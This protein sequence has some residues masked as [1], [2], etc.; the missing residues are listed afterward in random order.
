MGGRRSQEGRHL[1]TTAV[2]AG[3]RSAEGYGGQD[4]A[5]TKVDQLGDGDGSGTEGTQ[6]RADEGAVGVSGMARYRLCVH[7]WR[8]DGPRPSER[9][10][11]IG[12]QLPEGEDRS[13]E[14]RVGKEG[15]P[16]WA[17]YN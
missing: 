16:R 11:A 1:G 17:P 12:V 14:R 4:R 2:A 6:G 7:D 8:G 3:Q 13:E 10:E 5:V 9:G 15:R